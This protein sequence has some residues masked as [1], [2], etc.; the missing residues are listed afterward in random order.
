MALFSQ[1]RSLASRL[2]KQDGISI[3]DLNQALD[4]LDDAGR[5]AFVRSLCM[6]RQVHLWKMAEGHLEASLDMLVPDPIPASVTV[7]FEGRNSLPA[8]NLFQKRF[9]RSN[10]DDLLWGYNHQDMMWFT[11]PGAFVVRQD[12]QRGVL[13]VDYDELPS[14]TPPGWPEIKPNRGFPAAHIYGFMYDEL[15]P[16]TKDICIGK[17]FLKPERTRLVKITDSLVRQEQHFTLV[18]AGLA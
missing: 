6:K 14:H 12:T 7:I 8:F 9:T 15:R 1:E 3:A 10:R 17:N 16:V 11:G 2:D 13:I 18:R 4:A 5:L